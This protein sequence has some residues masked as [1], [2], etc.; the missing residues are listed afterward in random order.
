VPCEPT[1]P[2]APVEPDVPVGPIAV[3]AVSKNLDIIVVAQFTDGGVIIS[4]KIGYPLAFNSNIYPTV[5]TLGEPTPVPGESI[6]FM[7]PTS[8]KTTVAVFADWLVI[9]EIK[10]TMSSALLKYMPAVIEEQL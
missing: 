1:L 5:P 8:C 7:A 9:L 10:K 2:V 4:Y 3:D 6:A